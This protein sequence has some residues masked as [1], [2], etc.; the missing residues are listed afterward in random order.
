MKFFLGT[1]AKHIGLMLLCLLFVL[2][3]RGYAWD[4]KG[5]YP[6]VPKDI[7]GWR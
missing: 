5:G 1:T 7:A 3:V 4:S 6:T 2:A